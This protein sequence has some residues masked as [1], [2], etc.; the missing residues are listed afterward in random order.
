MA[1]IQS[2]WYEMK[3]CIPT[4]YIPKYLYARIASILIRFNLLTISMCIRRIH[5]MITTLP[6]AGTLLII[7]W[8]CQEF[9]QFQ[10]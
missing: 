2:A 5:F 6:E 4:K 3:Y 10:A 9:D 8:Y 1:L 7:A